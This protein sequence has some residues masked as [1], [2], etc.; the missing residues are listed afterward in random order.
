MVRDDTQTQKKKNAL[1]SFDWRQLQKF[2]NPQAIKDIDK[3]LDRLPITVGYNAIIAAALVWLF[4]GVA[5]MFASG[6]TE[7]ATELRAELL[8]VEA[9]K[10]PIPE[11]AYTLVSKAALEEMVDRVS[12]IGYPELTLKAEGDGTLKVTGPTTALAQ[13][14]NALGHI[15]FGDRGWRVELQSLCVGDECDS[16]GATAN[17][18]VSAARIVSSEEL[19]PAKPEEKGK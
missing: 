3:F 10:P 16:S 19:N 18:K 12:E 9:L 15:A 6:E 14:V 8:A 2:M 11:V 5:F 17:L 1:A 13:F 4:A 7:K